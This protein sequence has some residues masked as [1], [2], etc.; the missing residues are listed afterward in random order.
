MY[1]FPSGRTQRTVVQ[2]IDSSDRVYSVAF[3]PLT[4]RGRVYP[5]AYEPVEIDEEGEVRDPG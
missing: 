4:G 1:F 2:L 5:H 3:H